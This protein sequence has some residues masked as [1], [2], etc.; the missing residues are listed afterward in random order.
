MFDVRLTAI[1]N[2]AM[3]AE[4]FVEGVGEII[5]L[6]VDNSELVIDAVYNN[7]V[8]PEAILNSYHGVD[9][10]LDADHCREILT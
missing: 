3:M 2:G 5:G 1:L 6:N 9:Q 4:D 7:T 10:E 8:Q